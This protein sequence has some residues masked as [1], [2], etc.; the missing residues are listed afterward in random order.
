MSEAQIGIR[1]SDGRSH[2]V[3][4]PAGKPQIGWPTRIELSSGF[5]SAAVEAEMLFVPFRNS[6]VALHQTMQGEA[7]LVCLDEGHFVKITSAKFGHMQ[8]VAEVT[9]GRAPAAARLIVT[10]N[11]DQ[12]YLPA[13]IAGIDRYFP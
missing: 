12:T 13:I 4:I 8:L 10:M 5:F 1:I 7:R 2:L 9:D 3:L 6:L 11:I